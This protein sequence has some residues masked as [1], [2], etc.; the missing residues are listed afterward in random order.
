MA[1]EIKLD[2]TN[3]DEILKSDKPVIVDFWATWCGPC[4]MMG[5]LVEKLAEGHDDIVVGK[6]N[7][8]E[9]MTLAQRY[10]VASIP[11]F[12]RFEKGEMTDKKIGSMSYEDLEAFALK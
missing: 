6:V 1:K 7:V 8:D 9:A 10:R 2:E 11:T 12:I 4:Q 3:F 5:P